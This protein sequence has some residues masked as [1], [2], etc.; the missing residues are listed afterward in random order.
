MSWREIDLSSIDTPALLVDKG[1]VSHNI[2]AAID[3]AG[4][5]DHFRPHVKTHKTLEVAELQLAAG[6]TRYKCATIPEAEML[7]VY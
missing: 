6:I 1:L 7:G 5:V 3:Y 4:G 2:T